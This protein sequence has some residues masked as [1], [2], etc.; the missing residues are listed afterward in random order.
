MNLPGASDDTD[1]VLFG[2]S[3]LARFHLTPIDNNQPKFNFVCK[4]DFSVRF[5]LN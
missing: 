5:L 2:M 1:S 4:S 3:K